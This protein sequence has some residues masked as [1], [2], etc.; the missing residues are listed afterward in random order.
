MNKHEELTVFY[1]S[2]EIPLPRGYFIDL[3]IYLVHRVS[4]SIL[5][6]ESGKI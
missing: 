1:L 3:S 4:Q 2:N 6:I 5:Y